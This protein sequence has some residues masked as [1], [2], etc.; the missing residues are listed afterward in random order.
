MVRTAHAKLRDGSGTGEL[1]MRPGWAE[2]SATEISV[3]MCSVRA[4][5]ERCFGSSDAVTTAQVLRVVAAMDRELNSSDVLDRIHCR[6]AHYAGG[7]GCTQNEGGYWLAGRRDITLCLSGTN[8]DLRIFT[9]AS[10]N[11][12]LVNRYRSGPADERLL[13]AHAILH[14]F[15]HMAGAHAP[16]VH[17]AY[18]REE[19]YM[20]YDE[21]PA[22]GNLV[23]SDGAPVQ[24]TSPA[25]QLESAD[26]FAILVTI[27]SRDAPASARCVSTLSHGP[28]V[29]GGVEVGGPARP[30]LALGYDFRVRWR[31][32][33]MA[34][35]ARADLFPADTASRLLRLGADLELQFALHPRLRL[36][37]HG[38]YR[39]SLDGA[40]EVRPFGSNV[41]GSVRIPLRN[42]LGVSVFYNAL[43][44]FE[45]EPVIHQILLGVFLDF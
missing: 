4:A 25:R 10:T 12:V 28:S 44:L 32:F 23:G 11:R 8:N 35:G 26:P 29:M 18:E 30:T 3:A 24:P 41:G 20:M 37:V 5:I 27:L 39:F 33:V 43:R 36:G 6:W 7:E 9:P 31:Q 15:A 45:G 1:R 42:P 22:G 14:E 21:H 17:G 13:S 34:I 40:G 19:A 16:I 38:G 2:P